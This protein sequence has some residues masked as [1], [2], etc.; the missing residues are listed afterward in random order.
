MKKSNRR[1]SRMGREVDARRVQPS[2]PNAWKSRSVNNG[3]T[4]VELAGGLGN[5]LFQAYAALY[6]A[7]R[8]NSKAFGITNRLTET[9]HGSSILEFD[10]Q[11]SLS[12]LELP[13]TLYMELQA[14]GFI[15]SAARRKISSVG[16]TI[17]QV[18]EPGYVELPHVN[19]ESLY[20]RG[21]FQSSQYFSGL[22]SP[23]LPELPHQSPLLR[24]AM[25]IASRPGTLAVHMRRGDYLQHLTTHGLLGPEYYLPAVLAVNDT[26]G[27]LD[28]IWV[29]SDSSVTSEDLGLGRWGGQVK[30]FRDEFPLSD[31]ET[32]RVLAEFRS[33]VIGNS[34]FS[35][36]GAMLNYDSSDKL[37]FRPEKPFVGLGIPKLHY[38]D[39]WISIRNLH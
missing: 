31:I 14:L 28:N 19:G 36:W 16:R 17:L 34:T 23:I 18:N 20:L 38:P 10:W 35:Y 29:F 24:S 5:Q 11:G 37:V 22:K 3:A 30:F 13:A 15:S 39:T 6:S 9:S 25:E 33:I 2:N 8:T 27:D 1:Q 32:L 12:P 21:Y 7:Q 26:L 4:I